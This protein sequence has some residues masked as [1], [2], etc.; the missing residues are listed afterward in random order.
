MSDTSKDPAFPTEYSSEQYGLTGLTKREWFAGMALQGWM[1][2]Y[3]ELGFPDAH[4]LR[5][6]AEDMFNASDA[7]LKAGAE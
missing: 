5:I 3:G 6:I 1:A 2:T 7:M 4:R